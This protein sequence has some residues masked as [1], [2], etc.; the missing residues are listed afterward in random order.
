MADATL[1]HLGSGSFSLTH[2]E[3]VILVDPRSTGRRGGPE[4]PDTVDYVLQTQSHPDVQD[5][6]EFTLD[7]RPESLLVAP[8]AAC[9][10]V[11]RALDLPEDRL[12]D[13]QAWERAR[14]ELVRITALPTPVPTLGDLGPAFGGPLPGDPLRLASDLLRNLPFAGTL[15]A[16][17][18][19]AGLHTNQGFALELTDGPTIA[20][21]GEALAGRPPRRWLEDIGDVV[22]PDVL[23]AAASGPLVEGLVWANRELKP[24]LV[25]LYRARDPYGQDA[26]FPALP[27]N[28]FIEALQEDAPDV[29]VLHVRKGDRYV[30]EAPPAQATA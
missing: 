2:R 25:L 19:L 6:I 17:A 27:M 23:I 3:L 28:R 5:G 15:E 9:G 13:L 14:S 8:P 7:E 29:E 20:F 1:Q 4:L 16:A 22:T 18:G 12:L 21:L 10:R 11:Q 30:F 26:L 24:R